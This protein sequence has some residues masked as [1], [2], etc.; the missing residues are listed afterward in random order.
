MD[1]ETLKIL[2]K[3]KNMANKRSVKGFTL[4]ELMIAVV[5]IGLLAAIAYPSYTGIIQ[6]TRRQEAQRTLLESSQVMEGFYAMNVN[7]SGAVTANKLTIFTESKEFSDYYN[8]TAVAASSTFTL[9]A[10]PY[11]DQANDSCGTLTI[12]QNGTTTPNTS[13][14]W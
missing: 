6:K 10:T 1:R 3:Q 5:I 4:I 2:N 13:E 7:Y 11:G 9:T 12:T 14:C 8:L